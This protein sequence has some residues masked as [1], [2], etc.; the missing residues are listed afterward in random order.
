MSHLGNPRYWQIFKIY[1][2]FLSFMNYVC[3][4][5]YINKKI[6]QDGKYVIKEKIGL[7]WLSFCENGKCSKSY[8][9]VMFKTYI[10]SNSNYDQSESKYIG[11]VL[12]LKKIQK[13]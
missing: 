11:N 13:I 7:C 1:V 12:S 2:L 10:N 8:H 3:I 5:S 4:I 9:T 6:S